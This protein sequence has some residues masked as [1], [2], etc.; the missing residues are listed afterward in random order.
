MHI[1]SIRRLNGTSKAI[2]SLLLSDAQPCKV[3]SVVQQPPTGDTLASLL[4]TSLSSTSHN[5]GQLASDLDDPSSS[6]SAQLLSFTSQSLEDLQALP[7]TLETANCSLENQISSLCSRHVS[8]FVQVEKA[9]ATLPRALDRLAE[10][11]DLLVDEKLPSLQ[12]S[13]SVFDRRTQA[14]LQAKERAQ[15]LLEQHE[16]TLDDLLNIPRLLMTC[17]RANHPIEALMLGAH[18]GRIAKDSQSLQ[19]TFKSRGIILQALKEDS[20]IH[21][22]KLREDLIR[23]LGTRGTRLPAARR[24]LSLL[25]RFHDVDDAAKDQKNKLALSSSKICATFLHSHWVLLDEG[26]SHISDNDDAAEHLKNQISLW[27]EHVNDTCNIAL[28]LFGDAETARKSA[29]KNE[30]SPLTMISCFAY[31]AFE[32]LK[33]ILDTSIPSIDGT[34]SSPE[35]AYDSLTA[36]FTQYSYAVTSLSRFGLDFSQMTDIR[37]VFEKQVYFLRQRLGVW[38]EDVA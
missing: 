26:L 9:T 16:A 23:G 14:S 19:S 3:M 5:T 11:L 6:A 34:K 24:Y 4:R 38:E 8:S 37:T 7:S 13:I 21:L 32:R 30:L 12:H 18:I 27:R 2:T 28:A 29:D 22:T 36:L 25:Q 20:W 33:F 10:K 31:K 35:E 1:C 15:T 17:V